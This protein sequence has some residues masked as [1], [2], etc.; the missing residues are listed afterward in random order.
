[1]A[2][3]T[4]AL[5]RPAG[6]G[7]TIPG[8]GVQMLFKVTGADTNGTLAFQEFRLAPGGPAVRPH[9]HWEHDEYFYVVGRADRTHRRPRDGGRT[10]RVAGCRTRLG[11]R[12]S[13]R[14]GRAG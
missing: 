12:L 5:L 2:E 7:E 6:T 11:A 3:R 13:Q 1:M 4:K 10:R 14:V 9:I 8:P